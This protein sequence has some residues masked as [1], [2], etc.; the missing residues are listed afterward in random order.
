M[1][2]LRLGVC[3]FLIGMI[4][5]A[6]MLFGQSLEIDGDGMGVDE[7]ISIAEKGNVEL[8]AAARGV[9]QAER[10]LEGPLTLEKSKIS[11]GARYGYSA[12]ESSGGG[13]VLPGGTAAAE[14]HSLSVSA[15]LNLPIIPQLILGGSVELP[16]YDSSAGSAGPGEVSGSLSIAAYPF[17]APVFTPRGSW[18]YSRALYSYQYAAYEIAFS[19]EEA[20]LA[21]LTASKE[22]AD[23][24]VGLGIAEEEYAIIREEYEM[25]ETT[26]D[27]LTDKSDAL[28]EARHNVYTREK[29][30]L[31][32]ERVFY[33]SIGTGIPGI[34]GTGESGNDGGVKIKPIS[35][36]ELSEGVETRG[37]I[38]DTLGNKVP[39]SL[40]LS[41]LRMELEEMRAEEVAA[42]SYRPDLS[43]TAAVDIPT[44]G[45]SAG[46]TYTFS[47][48]DIKADEKTTLKENILSREEEIAQELYFLQKEKEML[49]SQIQTAAELVSLNR[50]AREDALITLEETRFLAGEGDRTTTELSRAE[51]SVRTKETS[52]YAA[53]VELYTLQGEYLLLYAEL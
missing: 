13:G 11:A 38:I 34:S 35:L 31:S 10:E 6:G 52:L 51:L 20:V 5:S 17:A 29:A 2:I 18:A 43:V 22:R 48:E 12:G 37:R 25:G 21:L 45:F 1:R 40:H 7:L 50:S 36:E 3:L 46:I 49:L 30:L 28:T 19:V 39:E 27:E 14:S 53:T 47:P 42:W 24:E 8:K 9:K 26:F 15:D 41:L 16:L 33:G 4:S 32:A 44:E 23:G